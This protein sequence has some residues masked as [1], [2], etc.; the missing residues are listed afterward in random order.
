MAIIIRCPSCS[1]NIEIAEK[2]AGKRVICPLCKQ[3]FM[4]P[5]AAQPAAPKPAPPATAARPAS[6]PVPRAAPPKPAA[7]PVA[8]AAAKPAPPAPARPAA[9]PKPSGPTRLDEPSA[10]G[11]WR[12]TEDASTTPLHRIVPPPPPPPAAPTPSAPAA[13]A[14]PAGSVHAKP[15]PPTRP[16]APTSQADDQAGER[17]AYYRRAPSK[18]ATGIRIACL[19]LVVVGVVLASI[20]L[21]SIFKAGTIAGG[22]RELFLKMKEAVASGDTVLLNALMA[23]EDRQLDEADKAQ[24]VAFL[25][26]QPGSVLP[27]K[28]DTASLVMACLNTRNF[29]I[30]SWKYVKASQEAREGA[31]LFT[32]DMEN[33]LSIPIVRKDV[34]WRL[35]LAEYT[36]KV[37]KVF[38][39][40][41][42]KKQQSDAGKT[43]PKA[44]PKEDDTSQKLD[45]DPSDTTKST[46]PAK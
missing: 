36:V 4:A 11:S 3:E 14:K 22:P 44:K 40:G 30:A 21:P 1:K 9:P 46:E 16:V 15:L 24:L 10:R 18:L 39:A 35:M 42:L 25:T 6:A 26:S 5:G 28:Q 33:T 2:S 17:R 20:Y 12:K 32:D 13:P 43:A 19:V 37:V 38:N 45:L 27:K 23:P 7:P 41:Q 31:V 29:R 34:G 8:P